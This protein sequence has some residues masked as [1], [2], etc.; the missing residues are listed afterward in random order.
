[1]SAITTL[2]LKDVR[3]FAG[4]H[5]LHFPRVV[6]LVGENSTGKTSVLA[7]ISALSKLA[8]N[9][10]FPSYDPF[11]IPPFDM[12]YFPTVAREGCEAF[13]LGGCVD[14]I[15]MSFDFSPYNGNVFERRAKITPSGQPSLILQRGKYGGFW[16][17]IGPSFVFNLEADA[18][19]YE[20][21]SQWL[22]SAVRY[23]HLPFSGDFELLRRRD[24]YSD[25]QITPF[26]RLTNYLMQLSTM[27]PE[28][29][30]VIRE[31][32][33]QVLLPQRRQ[34]VLPLVSRDAELSRLNEVREWLA[35]AGRQLQLFSNVHIERS[36]DEGYVLEVTIDGSRRNIVDV[37]LVSIQ[38]C[39]R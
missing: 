39:P 35:R 25:K 18:I 36:S 10:D 13:V 3:C 1:M 20:Q 26:V 37:G 14:G 23:Q 33:P 15:E 28:S 7:C 22:G 17:L 30:N 32:S 11:N 19:S 27:L 34:L 29:D 21:F 31:L 24:G 2:V 6:L 4:E 8:C 38:F 5:R 16:K 9:V 12:G